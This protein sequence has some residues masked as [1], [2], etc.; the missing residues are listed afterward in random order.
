MGLKP[1]IGMGCRL[2][3]LASRLASHH[4]LGHLKPLLGRDCRGYVYLKDIP[5]VPF[6]LILLLLVWQG[7][8]AT[9]CTLP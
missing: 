4:L 1:G 3:S 5:L 6:H 7:A 9:R 2:C 8:L